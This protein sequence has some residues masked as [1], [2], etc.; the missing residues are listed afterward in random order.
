MNF[1]KTR[2]YC[3][4]FFCHKESHRCVSV[5]CCVWLHFFKQH[6]LGIMYNENVLEEWKVTVDL[7]SGVY[8]IEIIPLCSSEGCAF[9]QW[10][11][12]C[13]KI[14]LLLDVGH[15]EVYICVSHCPFTCRMQKIY[16]TSRRSA[17]SKFKLPNPSNCI[18]VNRKM[19]YKICY[20]AERVQFGRVRDV[21]QCYWARNCWCFE[22]LHWL[23]HGVA[24]QN[25][26]ICSNTAVRTSKLTAWSLVNVIALYHSNY[27]CGLKWK[28]ACQTY[29]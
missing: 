2:P 8:S 9:E 7:G 15:H 3:I 24:F 29:I 6:C 11:W 1:C 13:C 5:K 22:G 27:W 10:T 20:G 18:D 23:H 28:T 16:L 25:T 19:L 12:Q 4:Y 17:I 14:L 21:T 26:C